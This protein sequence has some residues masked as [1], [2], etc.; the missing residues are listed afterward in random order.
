MRRTP[1]E[2]ATRRAVEVFTRPGGTMST[3]DVA[4]Q[5][6]HYSTLYWM[7]DEGLLTQLTRGVYRLSDIPG[8]RKH[9]VVTVAARV[10]SAILCLVSALEFHAVSY[11]HLRAHETRHDLVCR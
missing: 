7:R 4:A 1:S 10:P 11:T 3:G 8:L 6:V 9:D 2:N 5:G